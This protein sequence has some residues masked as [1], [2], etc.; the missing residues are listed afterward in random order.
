MPV[1]RHSCSL[2][3]SI[4]QSLLDKKTNPNLRDKDG[5]TALAHAEAGGHTET[6]KLLRD[7]DGRYLPD[8]L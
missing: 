3:T 5:W 1:S 6:V 7:G 2:R 8:L 4:T